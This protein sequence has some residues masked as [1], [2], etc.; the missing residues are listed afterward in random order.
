MNAKQRYLVRSV[1]RALQLLILLSL[2]S[3]LALMEIS[4][5]MHLAPSTAFRLLTTLQAHGFVEYSPENHKYRLGLVCL[6]LGNAYL[7]ESDTR[8]RA[9]PILKALRD[10]CKE[11]VH[12]AIL[13]GS[14][15]VYIEKLDALLPIGFMGSRVGGRAPAHCTA[16]GKAMLAYKTPPEIRRLYAGIELP[17]LTPNTITDLEELIDELARTKERVY[18]IDN[19]EHELGVKCIAVPVLDHLQNAVAALSVS[20]PATRIDQY[21]AEQSLIRK[22]QEASQAISARLSRG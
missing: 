4:Q 12:L 16:L 14:E 9:L 11:T 6:E 2:D 22:L 19:E 7:K 20:G 1:S 10:E 3:D 13:S 5:R 8:Q 17:R 15:V 21:I 18:A